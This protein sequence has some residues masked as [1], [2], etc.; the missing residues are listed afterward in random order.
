MLVVS[1]LVIIWYVPWHYVAQPHELAPSLLTAPTTESS[2]PI[3]PP[4]PPQQTGISGVG[5]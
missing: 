3:S 1:T 5:E 2:S 4:F